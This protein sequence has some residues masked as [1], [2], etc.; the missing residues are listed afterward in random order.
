M[1]QIDL[2]I[3]TDHYWNIVEDHILRG[4]GPTTAKSK[5]GY[6]LSGPVPT[7]NQSTRINASI[8]HVMTSHKEDEFDL[9]RFWS[10]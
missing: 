6:L 9:E 8:L 7:A 3:G 2:L 10:Q 5:I 1:F 4:P